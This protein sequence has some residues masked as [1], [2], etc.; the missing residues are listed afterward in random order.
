[1]SKCFALAITLCPHL[2]RKDVNEVCFVVLFLSGGPEIGKSIEGHRVKR[3][4][5]KGTERE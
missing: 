5:A 4:V 2:C 3:R 1:M